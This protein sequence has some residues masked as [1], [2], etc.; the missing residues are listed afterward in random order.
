[1]FLHTRTVIITGIVPN[2]FVHYVMCDS[3]NASD[4]CYFVDNKFMSRHHIFLSIIM[5]NIYTYV[6]NYIAC[7]FVFIG[8]YL[9]SY[10]SNI[11][12]NVIFNIRFVRIIRNKTRDSTC[13]YCTQFIVLYTPCRNTICCIHSV[14]HFKI[15]YKVY[16]I[17]VNTCLRDRASHGIC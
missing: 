6:L 5:L 2:H 8:T 17:D 12:N 7:F 3:G 13:C 1:M 14:R 10:I 15:T 9:Y 11:I 16:S 4:K